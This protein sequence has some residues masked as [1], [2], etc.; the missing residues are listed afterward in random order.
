[1]SEENI[2]GSFTVGDEEEYRTD[3]YGN[4]IIPIHIKDPEVKLLFE[5]YM[6]QNN[7]SLVS[8][9]HFECE[10]EEGK[11]L[12]EVIG[13]T[14]LNEIFYNAI[15]DMIEREEFKKELEENNESDS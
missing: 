1:M 3:K 14:I 12:K 10:L 4:S 6:V 9:Q 7:Y 13:D 5:A 11:Q 2:E 8:Q 15:T